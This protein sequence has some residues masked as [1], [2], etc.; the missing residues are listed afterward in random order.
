MQYQDILSA[1]FQ[2]FPGATW[3]A[4]S[5]LKPPTVPI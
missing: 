5:G 3:R 2:G 4:D 1:I